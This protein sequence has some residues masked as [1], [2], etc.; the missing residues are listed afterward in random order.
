MNIGLI[1]AGKVGC[2]LGKFFVQRNYT[3]VGYYSRS[4]KSANEAARFTQTK[5][6]DTI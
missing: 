5:A 3:V 4:S 2:T 1:G 6:F